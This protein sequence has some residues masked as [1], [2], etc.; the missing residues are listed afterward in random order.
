MVVR[1]GLKLPDS[2]NYASVRLAKPSMKPEGPVRHLRVLGPFLNDYEISGQY[3]LE[4]S[5]IAGQGIKKS[6]RGRF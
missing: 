5:I 1:I 2:N 4:K 6:S 3:K